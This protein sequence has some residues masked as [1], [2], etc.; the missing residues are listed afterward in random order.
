MLPY[1]AF[2]TIIGLYR[3]HAIA[4]ESEAKVP[5]VGNVYHRVRQSA[6]Y[7]HLMTPSWA[8]LL[9]TSHAIFN[10]KD[11]VTSQC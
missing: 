3:E 8:I 11:H 10:L 4:I 9:I 5:F 1:F 2:C 7:R 6:A